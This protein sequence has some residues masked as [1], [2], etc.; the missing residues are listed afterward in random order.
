MKCFRSEG[1]I[2]FQDLAYV[3]TPPSCVRESRAE[4]SFSMWLAVGEWVLSGRTPFIYLL[5][6]HQECTL[7]VQD[8]KFKLQ[9]LLVV[10]MQR[11]LKYHLLLKVRPSACSPCPLSHWAL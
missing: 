4:V 11:V 9:D 8:G 3:V 5:L 10:P 2:K 6:F 1:P 7:K